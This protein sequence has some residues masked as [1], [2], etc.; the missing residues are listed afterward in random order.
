MVN[1]KDP[2]QIRCSILPV[3]WT[4][5]QFKQRHKNITAY[6]KE[7]MEKN[8]IKSIE[9]DKEDVLHNWWWL[10]DHVF[11]KADTERDKYMSQVCTIPLLYP[12]R[13]RS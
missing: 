9:V 11:G 6:T 1:V 3:I 8:F 2:R 5:A 13:I 4:R 12:Y 10:V 7:L